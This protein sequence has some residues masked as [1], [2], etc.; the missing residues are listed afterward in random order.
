MWLFLNNI[1]LFNNLFPLRVA[2]YQPTIIT[3]K[4]IKLKRTNKTMS[5]EFNEKQLGYNGNK[6]IFKIHKSIN[7]T[8]KNIKDF[9]Q[10]KW[11][12]FEVML[13]EKVNEGD[14]NNYTIYIGESVKKKIGK[15]EYKKL[16]ASGKEISRGSTSLGKRKTQYPTI[17]YQT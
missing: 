4:I 17:T 10:N 8:D 14:K 3:D 1:I 13:F 7:L 16:R 9:F 5:N 2:L 15:E 11:L 6:I 12:W